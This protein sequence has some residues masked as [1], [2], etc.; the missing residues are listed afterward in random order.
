MNF[1]VR[2]LTTGDERFLATP[3]AAGW[4]FYPSF[5]P[6]GKRAAFRWNYR[7]DTSGIWTAVWPEGAPHLLAKDLRRPIGWSQ[8]GNAIYAVDTREVR[9]VIS[10]IDA[11]NGTSTD[12]TRL[13]VG[14]VV[15]GAA[16]RDGR[17]L[18]LTVQEQTG[19]AWLLE[20]LNSKPKP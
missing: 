14:V 12:L 6:G 3:T 9:P 10:M 15:G 13:P 5:S 7:P 16:S 11:A 1:R 19:D 20:N 2:D 8:D 17:T 4:L 18:V